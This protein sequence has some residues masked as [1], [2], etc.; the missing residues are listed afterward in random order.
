MDKKSV[1]FGIGTGMLA[2]VLVS[3]GTYAIQRASHQNA[4]AALGEQLEEALE[5]ANRPLDE[6]YLILRARQIG[7]W[8]PYEIASTPDVPGD[9]YENA[10]RE[11]AFE[12]D[13]PHETQEPEPPEPIEPPEQPEPLATP[14]PI[15][16]PTMPPAPAGFAMVD[17]PV[18]SFGTQIAHIL[19][20]AG[21]VP[22]VGDFLDFLIFHEFDPRLM[23][24]QFYLPLD[25]DFEDIVRRI[26]ANQ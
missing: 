16:Q 15:A 7:M 1:I 20:D 24:G 17:I 13:E 10:D 23:A 18:N 4:Y 5:I 22:N 8:F 11:P 6:D 25:G 26:L 19:A 21:V 14:E 2:M 3:F 9:E 12:P